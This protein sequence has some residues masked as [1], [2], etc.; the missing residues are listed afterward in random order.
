MSGISRWAA[1]VVVGL[2]AVGCI[3][4]PST[5]APPKL[6][7][8][9]AESPVASYQSVSAD[10]RYVTYEREDP[11]NFG[12]PP[13][14]WD[15]TVGTQ[16]R[17]PI[18]ANP[19]ST[20]SPIISAD[21]STV[22]FYS[23]S[24][25]PVLNAQ[26]VTPQSFFLYSV[27]GGT[28]QQINIPGG[29]PIQSL[30]LSADGTT[31]TAWQGPAITVFN[32]LTG[33]TTVAT[34]SSGAEDLIQNGG[35][36]SPNG[37]Y[38]TVARLEQLPDTP[39]ATELTL[40]VHDLQLGTVSPLW[41]GGIRNAGIQWGLQIGQTLDD[42]SVIFSYSSG[43]PV[44]VLN[45]TTSTLTLAAGPSGAIVT[46]VSSDGRFVSYRGPTSLILQ[47]SAIAA[48]KD[49]LHGT[50]FQVGGP[51]IPAAT[52]VDGVSTDGRYLVVATTDTD[53]VHT[54]GLYLEDRGA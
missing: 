48:V 29:D 22:A 27:A 7:L 23:Q 9:S 45:P 5:T 52:V 3:T 34:A 12:R 17:L 51:N 1:L 47:Q 10:G 6:T 42:G 18:D 32:A 4:P 28:F 39:P 13:Y 21:G 8:I 54:P 15:R 25:N 49:R 43:G 31:V 33:F 20:S 30:A 26:S 38:V 50:T 53:L 41:N 40:E 19:G 36:I 37:R 14:L 44:F 35:A 46:G 24:N 11:A 16:V 2:A